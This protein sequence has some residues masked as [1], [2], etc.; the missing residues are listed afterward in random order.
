MTSFGRF[1]NGFCRSNVYLISVKVAASRH[2]GYRFIR[3]GNP[4]LLFS[5]FENRPPPIT[6]QVNRFTHCQYT[7][8]TRLKPLRIKTKTKTKTKERLNS[9][10]LVTRWQLALQA[11]SSAKPHLVSPK[12]LGHGVSC[13]TPSKELDFRHWTVATFTLPTSPLPR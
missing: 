3:P 11:N 9:D 1:P 6:L 12:T 8:T 7:Y 10:H 5:H 13:S 4:N 2:L